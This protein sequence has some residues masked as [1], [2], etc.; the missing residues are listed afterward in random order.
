MSI[1]LS[2]VV[3]VYNGASTITLLAKELA[4]LQIEGGLE[5]ILVNDGSVDNSLDVCLDLCRSNMLPMPIVNLT[6]NFG[7]HNAV[8]SLEI[9]N[10]PKRIAHDGHHER[11]EKIL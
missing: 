11:L 4:S 2:V 5:L 3:P 9:R 1:A 10:E 6:R 8:C 7:E